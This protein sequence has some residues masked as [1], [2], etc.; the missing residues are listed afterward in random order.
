MPRLWSYR[1]GGVMVQDEEI[2]RLADIYL[3]G[4]RI[5]D[6]LVKARTVEEAMRAVECEIAWRDAMLPVVEREF[7]PVLPLF[8][9]L[10]F[11][12]VVVP[13]LSS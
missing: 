2:Q 3:E 13:I 10:I 8:S 4:R 9:F 7:G 5:L 6:E 11:A 1:A 12:K